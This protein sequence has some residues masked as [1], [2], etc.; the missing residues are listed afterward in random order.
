MEYKIENNK[1]FTLIEVIV[2]I[3][4]FM[5]IIGAAIGMF[6]SIVKHQ[7]SILAEQ[8]LLNQSSY[9]IESIS[10]AL[11]MAR[12][13]DVGDCIEDTSGNAGYN[14]IL[15]HYDLVLQAYTGIKFINQ[16]DTDSL[17]REACQEFYLDAD[18]VLKES[19]KYSV[20][21][22][23]TPIAITSTKLEVNS[24]VF[25][26]NGDKT[27]EGSRDIDG[28]QPRVTIFMDIGVLGENSQSIGKIQT[29]VSQRNLN[30]PQ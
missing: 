9:A 27:L 5:L 1:G 30:V 25:A 11:R 6:I 24:L 12:R 16:S 21:D 17:G 20:T 28:V 22:A 2:V 26:I 7:R 4:V 19:K 10:K 23:G 14:F 13:D 29:T 3:A 15:T 18:G 8:E